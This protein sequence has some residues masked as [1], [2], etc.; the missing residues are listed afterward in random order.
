MSEFCSVQVGKTV[1]VRDAYATFGDEMVE[2]PFF[3]GEGPPLLLVKR[4]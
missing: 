1:A 3:S 4:N 2:T